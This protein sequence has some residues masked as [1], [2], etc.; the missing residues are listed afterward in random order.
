MRFA[1]LA[2]KLKV[3]QSELTS[4]L[5]DNHNL[6]VNDGPN[7]K[8][9]DSI[10]ELAKSDFNYVSPI[11]Q[12]K[13]EIQEA[14]S[15]VEKQ[16]ED[17]N[18]EAKAIEEAISQP[19]EE[20]EVIEEVE[21][22]D[23]TKQVEVLDEVVES[24]NSNPLQNSHDGDETEEVVEEPIE[25][26]EEAQEVLDRLDPTDGV[27]K[28]P[29]V[30]VAGVKVMGKIDLPVEKVVEEE[31]ESEEDRQE[32]LRLEVEKEQ[33]KIAKI[34]KKQAEQKKRQEKK[35]A[36]EMKIKREKD[37][38]K[39]KAHYEQNHAVKS[40]P[41]KKK[42]KKKPQEDIFEQKQKAKKQKEYSSS[43]FGKFLKWLN[44]E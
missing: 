44:G 8:I 28:S 37:K 23:L 24:I 27:I 29:K 17:V 5:K 42:K 40:T 7:T 30:E 26:S 15:K 13:M 9:D 21:M 14:A 12:K 41:K 20:E 22:R 19:K 16:L 35:E 11:E 39:K 34:L 4:Y 31:V 10:V 38:E 2:R 18:E 3:S 1:Q 32:R 36:R 33:E 43:P 6:E 25:I